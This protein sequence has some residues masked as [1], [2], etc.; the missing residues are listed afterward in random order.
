MQNFLKRLRKARGL[1]LKELA[2]K[3]GFGVS[4][5]NN[6]ENGRS[7]ASQEFL[8]RISE[9]LG[10][11][12]AAILHDV[13]H[14]GA[15]YEESAEEIGPV[16]RFNFSTQ[17]G[18]RDAFEWLIEHMPLPR[19]IERVSSILN[20]QTMPAEQRLK[21]VKAIMPTLAARLQAATK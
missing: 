9:I 2:A 7:G 14:A 13:G 17:E 21:M 19:L 6:F 12:T 3:S 10:V 5:I 11:T 18:S 20:D 1:T 8:S 15:K 16:P 4:T